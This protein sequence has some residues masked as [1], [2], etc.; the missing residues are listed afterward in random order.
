MNIKLFDF[1]KIVRGLSK[2]CP[3]IHKKQLVPNFET[4]YCDSIS[5]IISRTLTILPL[6]FEEISILYKSIPYIQKICE[7]I[8]TPR[9][10]KENMCSIYHLLMLKYFPSEGFQN[11]QSEIIEK[12]VEVIEKLYSSNEIPYHQDL[13]E[14]RIL[15]KII[16]ESPVFWK[17]FCS[18]LEMGNFASFMTLQHI[19]RANLGAEITEKC[20]NIN[21][22]FICSFIHNLRIIPPSKFRY[23]NFTSISI[24][25]EKYKKY[26]DV[27]RTCVETLWIIVDPGKKYCQDIYKE[28][29]RIL[30]N[31]SDSWIPQLFSCLTDIENVFF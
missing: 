29:H 30:L 20:R 23:Q 15:S 31:I 21:P 2:I 12:S 3:C 26:P 17:K 25:L 14:T 27:V 5:K 24:F 7:R 4:L 11:I 13:Q 16:L 8:Y 28:A 1:F 9:T 18:N 19:L 22:E 6:D 10:S